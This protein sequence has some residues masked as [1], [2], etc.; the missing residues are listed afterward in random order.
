MPRNGEDLDYGSLIDT[1]LSKEAEESGETE[2]AEQ[3]KQ[4]ALDQEAEA[5]KAKELADQQDDSTGDKTDEQDQDEIR[6]GWIPAGRAAAMARA[7][8]ASADQVAT[9]I[10]DPK[11]YASA[12]FS[13]HGRYPTEEDF[14]ADGIDSSDDTDDT[15]E[16]PEAPKLKTR[17][18]FDSD[19]EFELYQELQEQKKITALLLSKQEA[20][21]KSTKDQD[22]AKFQEDFNQKVSDT[23][24][25]LDT[26]YGLKLQGPDLEE[27]IVEALGIAEAHYNRTGQD[28]A[29]EV[30]I[31]RA[32]K[33]LHFDKMAV[34]KADTKDNQEDELSNEEKEKARLAEI[35]RGIRQDKTDLASSSGGTTPAR[36]MRPE[37]SRAKIG[38]AYEDI[39]GKAMQELGQG[40]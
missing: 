25:R 13:A 15:G 26:D 8:N 23:L 14:A 10:N 1:V 6:P 31:E 39:V 29:P 24:T 40:R 16:K 34:K 35:A 19:G 9:L 33:G 18:D 21:E 12:F 37:V 27:L 30:L 2:N 4:A 38:S 17:D 11:E 36:G 7:K 28:L 32:A 5:A 20:Q 22:T 3:A